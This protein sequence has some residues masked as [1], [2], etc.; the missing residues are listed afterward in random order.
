[1]V[2]RLKGLPATFTTLAQTEPNSWICFK[3]SGPPSQVVRAEFIINTHTRT[4][5]RTH[6]GQ[7]RA[8]EP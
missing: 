5:T 3:L 2:A 6:T 4:H 7:L 8:A 1:M